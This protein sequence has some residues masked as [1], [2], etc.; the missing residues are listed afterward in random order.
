MKKMFQKALTLILIVLAL[1]TNAQIKVGDNPTNID[2]RSV[3]E[4]ESNSKALY[5][6]RLTNAQRDA[7]TGW[8]SGMFI[9]NI[10]DS[11]IQ[12][13]NGLI[14]N[15]LGN[16][17]IK[18]QNPQPWYNSN[19]LLPAIRVTD[20][21]YHKSHSIISKSITN[22]DWFMTYGGFPSKIIFSAQDTLN[23]EVEYANVTEGAVFALSH[24]KPTNFAGSSR[25]MNALNHTNSLSS[26]NY[27]NITAAANDASHFGTGNISLLVGLSAGSFNQSSGNVT[28]SMTV[29]SH[30]SNR[31]AGNTTD[32]ISIN[33]QTSNYGT[34]IVTN[35]FGVRVPFTQGSGTINNGYGLFIDNII[36]NR[37]WAIYTN[38]GK[39]SVGDTT[40]LRNVP[41]GNTATDELLVR[42]TS[43]GD[44]YKMSIDSVGAK[45]EPW[46][47]FNSKSGATKV[48]DTLYHLG[49]I[50]VSDIV[51]SPDTNNV[52]GTNIW[53]NNF[54]SGRSL[55]NYSKLVNTTGFFGQILKTPSTGTPTGFYDALGAE[56]RTDPATTNNFF[57]VTGLNTYP[58]HQGSG[59]VSI[60]QGVWGQFENMGTGTVTSSNGVKARVGNSGSGTTLNAIGLS[61]SVDRSAGSIINGYGLYI[62]DIN[63]TNSWGVYQKNSGNKNAFFGHTHLGNVSA[64]PDSSYIY[65]G[66]HTNVLNVE[67]T[68]PASN[69]VVNTQIAQFSTMF[70]PP[71]AYTGGNLRMMNI[72]GHTDPAAT[73]LATSTMNGIIVD[74]IHKANTNLGGFFG[75][76][77]T[78]MTSGASSSIGWSAALQGTTGNYSTG[79]ITNA[80]GIVGNIANYGAGNITTATALKATFT[81][82]GTIGTGYGLYIDPVLATNS[83]GIYQASASN[84]NTFFGHTGFG[85]YKAD[86]ANDLSLLFGLTSN[87]SKIVNN[88]QERMDDGMAYPSGFFV[89]RGNSATL[90]FNGTGTA[91]GNFQGAGA[92][93]RIDG[94]ANYTNQ[95]TAVFADLNF[96][97]SGTIN[98]VA[99]VTAFGHTGGSFTGTANNITSFKAA[100][101]GWGTGTIT[102]MYGLR[103]YDNSSTNT[104]IN[105]Y[106]V[107]ISNMVGTNA[108]GIY[109]ASS[110]NKNYFGGNVG[111]GTSNPTSKLQ[112]VGLPIFANN[113]AAL[114][115]GLTVGAFYHAGDGIVRVVY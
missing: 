35:S 14:W 88:T 71:A 101:A 10:T 32:L 27:Q 38:S 105:T 36:A 96:N 41:T 103:V 112:V 104:P 95:T 43:T 82:N 94:S 5:L 44:V 93:V 2:P 46:Y 47:S 12:Y 50:A 34:G 18:G 13:Y 6:P 49:K 3:L 20:T 30:A 83:W 60:G 42:R 57:W 40:Q 86:D 70:N 65:G 74:G 28:T 76:H 61:S 78:A 109:Q 75:I 25:A 77:S 84:L 52:R 26:V 24:H 56:V 7:Q 15:C 33:A 19:T 100:M 23:S 114:T 37:K 17:L 91:N 68:I 66:R 115:G 64:I 21:M 69:Y 63:A 108:Y 79:T 4:I 110:T 45:T 106:G 9:Y 58:A 97:G 1:N 85:N 80:L 55:T 8:K 62:D 29:N 59:T 102:N 39:V 51:T 53:N 67:E 107:H 81:N 72:H 11:C 92:D 31:G 113:A 73:N 98:D 111:I 22:P 16:G 99:G 89:R 87:Q 48:T 90:L 54:Y